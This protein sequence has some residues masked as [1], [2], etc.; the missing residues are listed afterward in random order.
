MYD[1][2]LPGFLSTWGD[3]LVESLK[4]LWYAFL[5][6]VPRLVGALLVI[7]IG[8]LVAVILGSLVAKVIRAIK[9]DELAEKLDLKKS[10]KR[11]GIDLSISGLIGW[12]VK[13]FFI[14]TFFMSAIDILEWTQVN[15]FLGEVV[16][17]LPNV[18]VSV[19][20]LLAGFILGRFVHDVVDAAVRAARMRSADFL[21]G[22]AQ[23]AIFVFTAAAALV[24]LGIAATLVNTVM[25]GVV[26]MLALAGG[27]AFG[28]GGKAHAERFLERVRKDLSE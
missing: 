8:W 21:A 2:S 14:L 19:I 24:Q 12:C 4:N 22:V 20:I 16:L 28:L 11:A 26:A 9:L 3:I 5:S 13:W 10:A 27:L 23:W 1:L 17:Y 15:E 7:V 6:F 25:T 18:V